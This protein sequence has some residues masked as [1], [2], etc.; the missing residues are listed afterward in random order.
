MEI[1]RKNLIFCT[2]CN[3]QRRICS[4]EWFYVMEL[5]LIWRRK[6]KLDILV[7]EFTE[8]NG[9]L[10]FERKFKIRISVTIRGSF[11]NFWQFLLKKIIK[12]KISSQIIN[13]WTLMY[14]N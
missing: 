3:M 5:S 12:G 14:T 7:C 4:S 10:I 9:F 1:I 11:S 2:F 8:F 6:I 13:K